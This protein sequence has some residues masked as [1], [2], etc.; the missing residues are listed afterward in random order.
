[1]LEI[2]LPN[3]ISFHPINIPGQKKNDFWGQDFHPW[4]D[5]T[6][7]GASPILRA[8]SRCASDLV[9]ADSRKKAKKEEVHDLMELKH[10]KR[11]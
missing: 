6:K 2:I 7:D 1:M 8:R 5:Q 3:M 10:S 4:E 11:R 9:T